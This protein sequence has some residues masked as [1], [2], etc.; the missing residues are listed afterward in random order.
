MDIGYFYSVKRIV[1]TSW[2]LAHQQNRPDLSPCFEAARLAIMQ[3]IEGNRAPDTKEQASLRDGFNLADE[4]IGTPNTVALNRAMNR[5]D[6]GDY[7]IPYMEP[8]PQPES[9]A[10][11]HK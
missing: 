10:S 4:W 2:I 5:Y 3:L 1:D 9:L 6:R 7:Q 11:G 8:T